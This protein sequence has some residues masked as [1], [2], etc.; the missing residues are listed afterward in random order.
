MKKLKV[1]AIAGMMLAST[2]SYAQIV[3]GKDYVVLKKPIPVKGPV[4]VAEFF[5][6]HC[7]HCMHAEPYFLKWKTTAPKD[8]TIRKEQVVWSDMMKP[9][10]QLHYTMNIL[11]VP[12]KVRD[13]AYQ[14]MVVNKVNL[15]ESGAG[16]K[17]LKAQ[18]PTTDPKKIDATFNSFGSVGYTN[19]AAALTRAYDVQGTPSFIVDGKYAV[20]NA[21]DWNKVFQTINELI[22]KAKKERKS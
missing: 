18:L 16:Q 12:Q 1:L 5:S 21:A 10:A 22:V 8:I 19:Q 14:A 7:V 3:E 17:F 6:Y 2:L 11:N 4:E 20:Q 15:M 13:N 9:L